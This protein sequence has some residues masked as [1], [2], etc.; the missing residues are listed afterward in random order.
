[1]TD[2]V[3]Y[4]GQLLEAALLRL[5]PWW[6][7]QSLLAVPGLPV[8]RWP[9]EPLL[10]S[11]LRGDDQR[12]GLLIGPRRVGK[13]T[14]VRQV[15]A[16]VAIRFPDIPARNFCYVDFQERLVDGVTPEAVVVALLPRIDPT[17]PTLLVLDE[18]QF[19]ADWDKLLR[20]VVHRHISPA[21]RM[22]ATGSGTAELR[23]GAA[24]TL[25]GR[26]Q[27]FRLGTLTFPEFVQVAS[28][29]AAFDPE[30]LDLRDQFARY[31]ARGG[32]P[33]SLWRADLAG[34]SS[35]LRSFCET[36][37]L[38]G[39]V[40]RRLGVRQSAT[41]AR[42]WLHIVRHPGQ[43]LN[44]A[45]LGNE[46]GA[47]R[48]TADAWLQALELAEL[49]LSI[50]PSDRRGHPES[51]KNRYPRAYPADHSLATA[52]GL[53]SDDGP[54]IETLVLRHLQS[55]VARLEGDHQ[56]RA[57]LT[58]WR[59]DRSAR[60]SSEIDF[61]VSLGEESLLIEVKATRNPEPDVA[62]LAR[63]AEGLHHTGVILVHRGDERRSVRRGEVV[64]HLWPLIEF[65][66]A[67]H[68]VPTTLGSLT[69][70]P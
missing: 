32:F 21:L 69:D 31:L 70:A 3:Q 7:D 17:Q 49:I 60:D 8:R 38:E 39:D 57:D 34:I 62:R 65:L 47:K 37:V 4:D 11:V 58:Y 6:E 2:F 43:V 28:G 1:M 51:G 35:Q 5:N 61:R 41:L 56:N 18:I 16:E 54:V 20:A 63:T 59:H 15:M 67:L 12:A 25:L 13:T 26:V 46:V 14:L 40:V 64:V 66:C 30:R 48:D 9:F 50:P 36:Y 22:L 53:S 52:Y 10:K 55:W 19:L 42:L 27:V 33:E 29:D 44:P 45:Q 24:D 68:A 23:R